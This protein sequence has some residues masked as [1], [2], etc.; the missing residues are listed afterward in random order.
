MPFSVSSLSAR[1]GRPCCPPPPSPGGRAAVAPFL[2]RSADGDN[3]DG[4]VVRGQP[5]ARRAAGSPLA[6]CGTLKSLKVDVYDHR[7]LQSRR[8]TRSPISANGFGVRSA[9]PSS[10]LP[11]VPPSHRRH[12]AVARLSTIFGAKLSHIRW[13]DVRVRFMHEFRVLF[14]FIDKL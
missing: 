10:S 7:E 3:L 1:H 8:K 9:L 6:L 11:P 12:R 13:C 5:P 4:D 2:R 14:H